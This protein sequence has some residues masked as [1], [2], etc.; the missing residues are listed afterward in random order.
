MTSIL[1]CALVPSV[2]ASQKS[3]ETWQL[4][5]LL[6]YLQNGIS[7]PW[8]RIPSV[9]AIFAAEASL[10]LLDS[11]HAQFTTISKFL[12]H[13]AS[14]NLQVGYFY[15]PTWTISNYEFYGIAFMY[16]IFFCRRAFHYF[17]HYWV[18]VLCISKL[19][20]CGCFSYY[21]LDQI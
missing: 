1:C 15:L 6:T 11:S 7:E 2:Q 9:V 4:Q 20:A 14:A 17:L 16:I 13:S 21:M 19:I 5:L 10:T 3:K 18:V 8:Q 12:M